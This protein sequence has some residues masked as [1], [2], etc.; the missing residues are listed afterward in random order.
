MEVD[1][2]SC[3][4]LSVSQPILFEAQAGDILH[5]A[6]WHDTLTASEPATGHVAIQLGEDVMWEATIEIP[7]T[8]GAYSPKLPLDKAYPKGTP[9]VF[10]LHNHGSNNWRL[11]PIELVTGVN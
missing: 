7:S 2:G 3:G 8:P 5:I 9:V 6:I 4:Y 10:H 11:L 1:T